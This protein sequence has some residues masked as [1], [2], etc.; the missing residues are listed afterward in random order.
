M[1]I[2]ITGGKYAAATLNAVGTTTVTVSGTPFVS[3][4]FGAGKPRVVALFNSAGT[5]FKGMAYVRRRTSISVLE[6]ERAFFDPATGTA[7]T[8]VSG[9]TLLVSKNWDDVVQA[10]IAIDADRVTVTDTITFGTSG[11][12][13]SLCFHDESKSVRISVGATYVAMQVSGGVWS[14]GHIDDY[15]NKLVYGGVNY[16]CNTSTDGRMFLTPGSTSAHILQVGGLVIASGSGRYP[17]WGNKD[18][19]GV[20]AG[21]EVFMKVEFDGIDVISVNA[22][23][24]FSSNATRHI[25]DS[26]SFLSDKFDSMLLRW[27]N[28]VNKNSKY[29]VKN[30][31]NN[32]IAITGS[33][34][35]GSYSVGADP[36]DRS[37]V[38]DIGGAGG[39]SSGQTF[40][41]SY[42]ATTFTVTATNVITT[43]RRSGYQNSPESVPLNTSTINW[44]YSDNYTNVLTGSVLGAIRD[45]DWTFDSSTTA[46]ATTV[47]LTV[48]HQTSTGHT[49]ASQRGPWTTR[50]RK[51]GYDE[52]EST[53]AESDYDLG[54]SGIA[55]NVS[56]GGLVN[57]IAR[58]SLTDSEATALAYTGITVTD[59]GASP[60]SWNSKA[61]SITSE[62]DLATY[63]TRTAA[64]VFAHVKA[65]IA[66]TSTWGGKVGLLWHVLVEESGSDFVSQRGKSGGA[67]AT[68][69][70]VRVIDQAGNPM[71]GFVA[72]VADDGTTYIPPISESR[73]LS[74]DGLIAGS[75]VVIFETGTTTEIFRDN[76]SSTAETWSESATGSRTVDYTIMKAGYRPIR[77]TGVTVTGAVSGGV[78][79]IDP[80]QQADRT[81]AASSGL[82]YTT[83]TTATVGTKI[84]TLRI[85]STVQNWYS[86]MIEV[87]IAQAA[88][89]NVEFPLSSNGPNSITLGLGWEWRG[90]T[91]AGTGIA[92]TSLAL[93][94]RDGMRY[95]DVSGVTTASWAALLSAGVSAGMLVRYQ[96]TDGGTTTDAAATGNIDQLIQ[97]YGDAS[98]GNF[99][100]TGYMVAKV[101]EMGFDQAEVDVVAQY[102]T[103][104]DQLYVIALA[105]A[106]NGV[107][108]GNPSLANP[109]TITDHGATQATWNAKDFSITITDSAAGNT[110]TGI[111]R[112]LRYNFETG[113]TFQ[114]KDGFNWH[115][116][117]QSNG[118]DFK[119]VRGI[120]YGDIGATLKGVRV[121]QN[122][123][124]TP[125]PDFTLFT[126]DDGTTYAPPP[127]ATVT[128]NNLTSGSRVQLYDTGNNVELY[129]DVVGATTLNYSETYSVD[130]TVRV[131]ITY[132]SGVTAKQFIE[133]VVGTF[134]SGNPNISYNAAQEDDDTYIANGVDGSGITGIT[135]T[136][137]ATDLVNINIPGGTAPWKNIYAAFVYWIDTAVGITDD[138]AYIEAVDP[139]N[140]LLTSMKIKNTSS[141]SVPLTITEGYARDSGTGSIVDIID[142]TG[143]N[144]YPLVDHVVSSVVTV[145]GVNVITGD[146]ADIPAAPSAATVAATV[147]T[148]AQTTPIHSDVKFI[149]AALVTGTGQLNDQWRGD[150]VS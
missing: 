15:T 115:D 2:T 97:I 7:V 30:G 129:N 85:A 149:N 93:L 63:P 122:D 148:A 101:Q 123:G 50:I 22:G 66:S 126:A 112:W 49:L 131:R 147:L 18:S 98:H 137:A 95:T 36:G 105:P 65:K 89:A 77:V 91:T 94:S 41:R 106:A 43:D 109:P 121:V 13:R 143:G 19:S 145:G 103:L 119:T 51:Y 110:G 16:S 31:S 58:A 87:W 60:V 84:F 108:T 104:E 44:Y 27:G 127:A 35:N 24:N 113:G 33:E 70:G 48:F 32:P 144:I 118:D 17:G 8:Q 71:P 34:V 9:D 92:N 1:A 61:Y 102:G 130:R 138:I 120:I 45:S 5:T 26:C 46:A 107:A 124:T 3:S 146:I 100:R 135:F 142:T 11:D 78:L 4:D 25:V 55:K 81:Y 6:L 53:V 62:V 139:A 74:F 136:D 39:A 99:D 82:T 23:G 79:N 29:K 133:A 86:H 88:F 83:D 14:Q 54:T 57:Q 150:G 80:Q 10:G 21:T 67:G 68:L 47:P 96:Q 125:H 140:Y 114:G 75:Q 40:W 64:Q 42:L 73:G 90:W 12:P 20:S 28:G 132:V 76:N 141:P 117:V 38:S 37:I 111:M 69:K 116:L 52:L 72:M 56:F 59:H 128:I 134:T